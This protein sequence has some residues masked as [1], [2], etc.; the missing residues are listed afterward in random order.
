MFY[1]ILVYYANIILLLY[2]H[3]YL[4]KWIFKTCLRCVVK[5]YILV[6]INSRGVFTIE[7]PT[8]RN[9]T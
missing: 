4:S 6:F 1:G 5:T 3:D 2:K 9:Y 8:P 7:Q